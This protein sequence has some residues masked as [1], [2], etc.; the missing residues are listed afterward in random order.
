V[1][2]DHDEDIR[3]RIFIEGAESG[4]DEL[5]LLEYVFTLRIRDGQEW[6]EATRFFDNEPCADRRGWIDPKSVIKVRER[7]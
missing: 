2:H 7:R 6:I 4:A 1:D 3:H 5:C